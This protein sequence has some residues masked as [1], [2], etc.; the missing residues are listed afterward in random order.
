MNGEDILIYMK[1]EDITLLQ[2]AGTLNIQVVTLSNLLKDH[3]KKSQIIQILSAI[4]DIKLSRIKT[5]Y[6]K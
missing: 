1:Q 2:V 6:Q 5:M 4:E 3:L